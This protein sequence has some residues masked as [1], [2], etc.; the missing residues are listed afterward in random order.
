MRGNQSY[1]NQKCVNYVIFK[2]GVWENNESN[3]Y[4]QAQGR[5]R[6]TRER[7]DSGTGDLGTARHAKFSELVH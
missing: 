2:D 4:A 5:H 6:K 7:L 1:R 3:R